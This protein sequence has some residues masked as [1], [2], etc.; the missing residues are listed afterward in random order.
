MNIMTA[1][2]Y[3]LKEL[4]N[5]FIELTAHNCNQKC[6]NCFINF[7]SNKKVKDFITIDKIRESLEDTKNENLH[8]IYLTGAEPMTHPD[9]NMIL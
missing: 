1:P 9:F 6:Q 2:V 3:K 8:C 5:F 4:N 7:P